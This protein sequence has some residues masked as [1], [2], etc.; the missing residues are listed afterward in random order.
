MNLCSRINSQ[1]FPLSMKGIEILPME[2]QDISSLLSVSR[3]PEIWQHY[4]VDAGNDR[5]F[6]DNMMSS[7]LLKESGKRFP[8]VVRLKNSGRIIG[9]T[10]FLDI[11]E[12]HLKLEIGFTWY[13][14]NDRSKGINEV[15]KYL[16]LQLCFDVLGLRRVQFKTN[17]NNL[18]SR[19][20]LMKIGAT[21]EGILRNDM[22]GYTGS[23]RNSAY[24]S[25]IEDEW[26]EVKQ[27]LE[28][29]INNKP[30]TWI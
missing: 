30:Q 17:E 1:S 10:Q 21:F 6:I 11:Q 9:G 3:D 2:E 8:F 19:H 20:A 22:V 15:C 23:K 14:K 29:L 18:A 4:A 25:I 13:T 16:L 24:Y 7:L 26:P 5:V 28:Q 27:H 12:E